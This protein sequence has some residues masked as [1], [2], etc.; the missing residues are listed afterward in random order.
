MVN[1]KLTGDNGYEY[2]L[3]GVYPF[4]LYHCNSITFTAHWHYELEA[5]YLLAGK[6]T[7]RVDGHDY[8]LQG[9]DVLCI[10]CSSLHESVSHSADFDALV[11]KLG[12]NLLGT[13]F[14]CFAGK[15]FANPVISLRGELSAQQQTLRDTL[16]RLTVSSLACHYYPEPAADY[17]VERLEV[18]GDLYRIAAYLAEYMP[19]LEEGNESEERFQ[20]AYTMHTVLSFVTANYKQPISVTRAAAVAGYEKTRFC[21]LFKKAMG[22]SFH[23]H[24]TDYR[25]KIACYLLRESDL[26]VAMIGDEVGISQ[27]KTLSRLFRERYNMT[28]SEYRRANHDKT[29]LPAA[30]E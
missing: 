2:P 21:Q 26:S 15:Q 12:F 11:L 14:D 4:Y 3:N 20:L 17:L 18:C 23:Q 19:M 10:S 25:L 16:E 22:V 1:E 8:A 7:V 13:D 6:A 29:P 24:L 30:E 27:P 5:I 28:P 9:G